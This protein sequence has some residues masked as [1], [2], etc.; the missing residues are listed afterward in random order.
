MSKQISFFL[1][2]LL[3]FIAA[4]TRIV[5]LNAAPLGISTPE[6]YDMQIAEQIRLGQ[7]EVL[8][9]VNDEGRE[10][11]YHTLLS[12]NTFFVGTSTFGYRVTGI[13]I[14]MLTLA[15]LY[16]LTRRLFGRTTGVLA[17]ASAAVPMWS[18]L[19]GRTIARETILPLLVIAVLLGL[20]RSLP[21]YRRPN[22]NPST[23]PFALLGI[24]LGVGF[25]I[26]PA[27]YAII[28]TVLA[29]VLYML[30]TRQPMSRRTIS[31]LSFTLIILV[32]VAIPYTINT[33]QQPE[34]GG[35]TRF[36]IEYDAILELG[37]PQTILN[38]FMGLFWRG[39]ANI[40]H[41]V[42]NRPYIDPISGLIM[43][44]GL[45]SVF[46]RGL[47][48][49]YGFIGVSFILLLPIALLAPQSPNFMSYPL[50][51]P[52][53]AILFG[54]GVKHLHRLTPRRYERLLYGAV[55]VLLVANLGW[56][57]W[58]IWG[59]WQNHP[60]HDIAYHEHLAQTAAYLNRTADD[61]QTVICTRDIPSQPT[62]TAN[63]NYSAT[64]LSL[65]M[66]NDI[67][68]NLRYVDC[69]AGFIFT[70][71]GEHQQ[72]I[73]LDDS[74][75]EDIPPYIQEWLAQGD[76]ILDGI[77][78]DSVISMIVVDN[79]GDTVGRFLTTAPTGYAPESPGGVAPAPLPVNFENGLT[80]LGYEKAESP[81]TYQAGD[82]ITLITYWRADDLLPSGLTLFSHI[83]FDAE[84]IVAQTDTLG[85][86]P[87][88]LRSRDVFIQMTRIPLPEDTP[89]ATY[90][91]SIGAYISNADE[92]NTRL[93]VLDNNQPRGSRLF[94]SEFSVNE[95]QPES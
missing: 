45:V 58:S 71:G 66:S 8:Y 74:L 37:T 87:Q 29:F 83:L 46:Q 5:G 91:T 44:F 6:A 86:L 32:I 19:M 77:P 47:Q 59:N 16:T 15:L 84:T 41:N 64:L 68:K 50:I 57:L 25:Y 80:F 9:E 93:M 30:I 54:L 48:P 2:A 34:R 78:E 27:H 3:L 33:I 11:F 35:I 28:G 12:A 75:R 55:S 76:L 52:L 7:V 85:V 89:S 39:D 82:T 94:L 10:G 65:M 67:E 21:V 1:A 36:F 13:W 40:L 31:Y 43:L 72:V 95:P 51:M 61:T 17:L 79:L 90:Q 38:S 26:H 73:V 63:A 60:E 62:Q 69:T 22:I 4:A 88:R 42:P 53:L 81:E 70:N 92:E 14:A 23:A 56:S 18:I 49:R 24:L 20:A